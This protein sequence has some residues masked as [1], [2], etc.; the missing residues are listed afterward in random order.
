VQP[1]LPYD[2]KVWI[3]SV[4]KFAAS[5]S[6]PRS[7]AMMPRPSTLWATPIGTSTRRSNSS[8]VAR[9]RVVKLSRRVCLAEP[10]EDLSS[11]FPLWWLSGTMAAMRS[12]APSC[13][14]EAAH[15][16]AAR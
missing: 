3:A 11:S 8:G 7:N 9:C 4:R 6:S 5:S 10:F 1:T 12:A 13:S 14:C 15:R 16:I 2:A